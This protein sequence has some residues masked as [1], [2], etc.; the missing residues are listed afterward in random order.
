M[1]S[2]AFWCNSCYVLCR[3]VEL[4]CLQFRADSFLHSLFGRVRTSHLHTI[5][6]FMFSLCC[7]HAHLTQLIYYV[8]KLDFLVCSPIPW[9]FMLLVVFKYKHTHIQ[10]AVRDTCG[11]LAA[12]VC[13][14]CPLCF[15]NFRVTFARTLSGYGVW[16]M[17]WN[18]IVQRTRALC[19][20]IVVS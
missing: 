15:V 16:N 4:D 5:S 14:D 6:S 12:A 1:P 18:Q 17:L 8:R 10:S 2:N 19:R 7:V 11:R 3:F 13:Y 20:C 9:L